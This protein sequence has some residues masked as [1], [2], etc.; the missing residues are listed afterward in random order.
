MYSLSLC[1]I[2]GNK[3]FVRTLTVWYP[4]ADSANKAYRLAE[5]AIRRTKEL[6][7]AARKIKRAACML[8]SSTRPNNLIGLN[9]LTL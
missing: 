5:R 6:D 3:Y 9:A 4:V 1:R 2:G 8:D 7:T